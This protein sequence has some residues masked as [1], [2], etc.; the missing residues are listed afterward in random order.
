[1]KETQQIKS[2]FDRIVGRYDFLNH[3]LSFGQDFFWRKK[4]A[5]HAVNGGTTIVLDLA[6][7]TADSARALLKRGAKVVGVDISFEMLRTGNKKIKKKKRNAFF[8]AVVA[9]GYRL[10]F[11][12]ECFDAVTCAFGIRNMH[13]TESAVKEIYRVIKKG[14]RIVILEFSIPDG[15]FRKPYLL[16]LKKIVPF[17]A[18]VFS[19]RSAYEYL[20]S[21]IEGFYKPREIIKLLE[22]CSFRNIKAIPLSFRSVYLYVGKKN[23]L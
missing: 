15:F 11:R 6:T 7:G 18:S 23:P 20:G 22:N 16:Y 8:S 21:S 14:G 4:M 12:D 13:E 5:E 19:V 17:I 2:M 9:S 10:P 3:L 1:M